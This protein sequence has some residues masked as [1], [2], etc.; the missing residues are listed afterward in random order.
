VR[1]V[2]ANTIIGQLLPRGTVKGGTSLKFRYGD[3]ATRFTRD[4]DA[5]RVEDI[6]TFLTNLDAKLK[7]GWNGFTGRIVR[8]EPAHP[9]DVPG[10]Y[11][12]QPFEIKLEYNGKSWVT[13]PLEVGHDE[14][15]DTNDP[16]Y[17]ISSD[18]VTLFDQLGFPAPSPIA[19]MPIPHQIAQKLHA[20]SGEGSE[21]AHDLIDLQII[22]SN[23][24]VDY[25]LTKNACTRLF[26]SRKLQAWPPTITRGDNWDSLYAAQSES[27]DVLA[28]ID[29][30]VVW[31]NYLIRR[32]ERS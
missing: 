6:D 1:T 24:E 28:T 30:A 22:V 2:I 27:L 8:K 32:I 21:R 12:M 29:E 4:L 17:Y 23:E 31:T 16:D 9:K 3:K 19:L 25:A 14:I 20:L 13:V 18:I 5:A 26:D 7:S 15:G 10:E 11:I